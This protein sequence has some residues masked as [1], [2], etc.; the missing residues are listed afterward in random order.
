MAQTKYEKKMVEMD[1]VDDDEGEIMD[2]SMG[3]DAMIE[4][5]RS[6]AITSKNIPEM[7]DLDD[8]ALEEEEVFEEEE[9]EG[10]IM[11][12]TSMDA[13]NTKSFGYSSKIDKVSSSAKP[14]FTT[15]I[16]IFDKKIQEKLQ[17]R[18]KRFAL[19]PEE[20]NSIND[21]VLQDLYDSLGIDSR[22]KKEVKFETVHIHGYDNM[23]GKDVVEYFAN[24]APEGIE[25]LDDRSCNIVWLDNVSAARALHFLSRAV[26]GMPARAPIETFPKEF[27]NNVEDDEL[28]DE[29]PYG[30]SI[31]NGLNNSVIANEIAKLIKTKKK[32]Y[33][34][35]AVDIAEISITIP[36]GY[37]RLG[38][39]HPKSR[40]LLMRFG[41]ITDKYPLK[42]EKCDKYYKL[43]SNPSS[44]KR[45]LSDTDKK[46]VKRTTSIFDNNEEL[47]QSLAQSKNPWGSLA[48]NWDKDS[49]FRERDPIM[50]E[51]KV[52]VPELK[53]PSLQARL[54]TRKK[55][56]DG[57]L[58]IQGEPNEKKNSGKKSKVP[59]MTM[60]ADEEEYK[61]KEKQILTAIRKH[62]V[63]LKKNN[64]DLRNMLS[65]SKGL[66]LRKDK[67][68]HDPNADLGLT[69]KNRIKKM[70]FAVDNEPTED[71]DY[72]PSYTYIEGSHSYANIAVPRRR[73]FENSFTESENESSPMKYRSPL[74]RSST[75]R[76][77][78]RRRRR[79][80]PSRSRS[81]ERRLYSDRLEP[82]KSTRPTPY[83]HARSP[84]S[85]HSR[86]KSYPHKGSDRTRIK[87]KTESRGSRVASTIWTKPVEPSEI[88]QNYEESDK[89]SASSSDNSDSLSDS[90]ESHS[91]TYR[92]ISARNPSRPGFH[93]RRFKRERT[94]KK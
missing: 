93:R 40:G 53:N 94:W 86:Y 82:R 26:E 61:K 66:S 38:I 75:E 70:C 46:G 7:P 80:I 60:Y 58:E 67:L 62:E 23:L 16:N 10:E 13:D 47:T 85:A 34:A 3:L 45:Y 21:Q 68:E 71:Y 17:E 20:I 74:L 29:E 79:H 41:N 89:S 6:E 76:D 48:K 49:K 73:S 77:I 31:Q 84:K 15:G 81:P 18:A 8:E 11:D 19:K 50:Y 63:G 57:E 25:W 5:F 12:D 72:D 54:G 39:P 55:S 43:L 42:S 9:E 92:G 59:R 32:S 33:L 78:P 87:Y 35:N 1:D 69:L 2:T 90:S 44:Q 14:I 88:V 65:T 36:P 91:S 37:W 27:L 4:E 64:D 30:Q 22:N 28:D 56:Y 51:N 52:I 83:R 24:Y